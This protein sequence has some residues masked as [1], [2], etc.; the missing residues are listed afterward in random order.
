MRRVE[1][2]PV[3]GALGVAESPHVALGK[4][5]VAIGRL[6]EPLAADRHVGQGGPQLA[7]ERDVALEHR[8]PV[9]QA[10]VIVEDAQRLVEV[11][12]VH[13]E[14]GAQCL[15]SG[16]EQVAPRLVRGVDV[17]E[18][19]HGIGPRPQPPLPGV[20]APR[21][22]CLEP[23]EPFIERVQGVAA[24]VVDVEHHAVAELMGAGEEG[25]ELVERLVVG[26][27]VAVVARLA[28]GGDVEEGLL[29]VE[30]LGESLDEGDVHA[31]D[32]A[33]ADVAHPRGP[34]LGDGGGPQVG[35][36]PVAVAARGDAPVAGVDA[37]A[38][39]HRLAGRVGGEGGVVHRGEAEPPALGAAPHGEPLVAA[40]GVLG[41]HV[42]AAALA[43]DD[44]ELRLPGDGIVEGVRR[45]GRVAREPNARAARHDDVH[46]QWG[47]GD[48]PLHA[49]H[50]LGGRGAPLGDDQLARRLV[51]GD[52]ARGARAVEAGEPAVAASR[53]ALVAQGGRSARPPC[54]VAAL[55]AHDAEAAL[56]AAGHE[57]V[58]RGV[59]QRHQEPALERRV[60]PRRRHHQRLGDRGGSEE[61]Q[62]GSRWQTITHHVSRIVPTGAT[63][64]GRPCGGGGW[65]RRRR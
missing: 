11:E 31:H 15:H 50:A 59:L 23:L 24:E 35:D 42:E 52:G 56:L 25:G 18:L 3:P 20:V 22:A 7:V 47:V 34:L 5:L 51:D 14:R 2:G 29:G 13:G 43:L 61:E 21:A 26:R 12:R 37:K 65:P 38:P 4:R 8:H 40:H 45:A 33:A 64:R 55:D 63:A 46:L 41:P 49:P 57:G 17:G 62:E 28:P 60:E 48:R 19:D 36:R 39:A 9:E 53:L 1:I 44:D 30:P 6:V 54:P 16:D 27:V 32:D 10:V 58:A